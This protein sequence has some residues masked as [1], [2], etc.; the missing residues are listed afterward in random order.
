[1]IRLRT[2]SDDLVSESGGRG[3]SGSKI[4]RSPVLEIRVMGGDA[5]ARKTRISGKKR[6]NRA[7]APLPPSSVAT[8][9][10]WDTIRNNRTLADAFL[11]KERLIR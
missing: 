3:R 8:V 6:C 1:M 2:T 7:I 11:Q 4:D 10:A 9:S 5:I